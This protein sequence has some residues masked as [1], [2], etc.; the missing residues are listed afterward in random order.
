MSVSYQLIYHFGYIESTQ[1]FCFFNWP[2]D[3]VRPKVFLVLKK[4]LLESRGITIPFTG[5]LRPCASVSTAIIGKSEPSSTLTTS[6]YFEFSSFPG[7]RR[8]PEG[9][10]SLEKSIIRNP[11]SAR[12]SSRNARNNLGNRPQVKLVK[13]IVDPK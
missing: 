13:Q 3:T 4:F 8:L 10:L 9:V 7:L 12:S 11:N 2:N 1:K 5:N 6:S